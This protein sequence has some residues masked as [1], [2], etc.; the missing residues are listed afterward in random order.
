MNDLTMFLFHLSLT[1]RSVADSSCIGKC[2]QG[3]E[4]IYQITFTILL[5]IRK[6]T[7]GM[8]CLLLELHL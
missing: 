8:H 2:K 3:I 1:G 7:I 5:K 6:S 4:F